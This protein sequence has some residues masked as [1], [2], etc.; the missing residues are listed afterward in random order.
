MQV[1]RCTARLIIFPANPYF[2]I[3]RIANV[4]KIRNPLVTGRVH[5]DS[6]VFIPLN[7]G[8]WLWNYSP[9]HLSI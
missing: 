1:E 2:L 3:I 8:D 9:Q 6:G 7:L 4:S 5:P